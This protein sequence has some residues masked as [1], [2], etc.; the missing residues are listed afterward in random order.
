MKLF[1]TLQL[2]IGAA[3]LAFLTAYGCGGNVVVDGTATET[4][5]SETSTD[6][7]TESEVGTGT[8]TQTETFTEGGTETDTV[9]P[10]SCE[11][12]C[13]TLMMQGG[14]ADLCSILHNGSTV[15]NFC[16]GQV[17]L[18]QCAACLEANCVGLLMN[19]NT[20]NGM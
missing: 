11:C 8:D 5:T 16:E 14:C 2:G 20:C 1:W 6:V 4:D 19:P 12:A 15:P 7:G 3:S 18:S 17:P 10:D 9:P 13:V